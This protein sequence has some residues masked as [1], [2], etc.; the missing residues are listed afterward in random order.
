[1]KRDPKNIK[2]LTDDD[3]NVVERSLFFIQKELNKTI[4]HAH[5]LNIII[6]GAFIMLHPASKHLIPNHHHQ[7]L[8]EKMRRSQWGLDFSNNSTG[9]TEVP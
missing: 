8:G 9:D 6:Y 1:M 2:R 4:Q 7:A 3:N 5:K